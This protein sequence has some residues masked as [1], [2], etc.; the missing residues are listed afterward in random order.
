MPS[1]YKLGFFDSYHY[2]GIVIK[3]SGKRKSFKIR[4]DG[5]IAKTLQDYFH[6]R[7]EFSKDKSSLT[8]G[9]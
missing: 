1:E 9:K 7:G 5:D 6:D 3:H 8:V 2:I 4:I